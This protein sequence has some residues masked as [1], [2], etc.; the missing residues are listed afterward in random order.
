VDAFDVS[1]FGLGL[2]QN[3]HIV[4]PGVASNNGVL[5]SGNIALN[6]IAIRSFK[7]GVSTS[8]CSISL[9]TVAS[10]FCNTGYEIASGSSI[11]TPG[12]AMACGNNN[13]G[14]WISAST[15]FLGGPSALCT[16]LGNSESGVIS[17]QNA[18]V[19]V[20]NFLSDYNQYG[21]NAAYRS[22]LRLGA[23]PIL[24]NRAGGN[25]SFD[26]F[27]NLAATIIGNLNGGNVGTFSPANG[28][29]GNTNSYISIGA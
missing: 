20:L 19:V 18:S 5:S 24:P 8:A 26:A 9:N 28:S 4:G 7:F 10:C 16:A 22:L 2:L 14:F 6:T 17:D 25:T 27:A 21:Y 12:P 11:T 3:F 13:R 15:A 23:P 1:Q 29:V